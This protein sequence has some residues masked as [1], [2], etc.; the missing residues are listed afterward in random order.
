MIR[1]GDAIEVKKIQSRGSSI[2]LNSSYP[3]NRLYSESTQITKECKECE[4]W[5]Q[6]DILYII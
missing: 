3:K 4:D 2:S 6:K 5:E 1:G